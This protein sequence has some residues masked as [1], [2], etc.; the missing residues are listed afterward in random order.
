VSAAPRAEPGALE[1][2]REELRRWLAANRPPPP[3]FPLPQN[4]LSVTTEAQLEWLRAWQRR[5][6]EA[7]YVGVEWPEAYGGR[8]LARGHQRVVD[9]ETARAGAPF[10][11]NNVALAWAGP[12][13][14]HHGTEAQRRRYLKPLLACE[15]IWCQGFSEPEAGSDL[16]S[17]Q[18]RARRDGDAWV[19]DGHK[20][21]TSLGQFA[22]HMILLARTDPDAPKH[23]GISYFLAPMGVPGVEVRP[24]VKMTGEGGFNQVLFHEARIPA[25]TLL[26]RE[27]EGWK[28]AV[29]TLSF[30]RGASEGSGGASDMGGGSVDDLLAL[31]RRLGPTVT[32]DPVRRDRLA[33]FVIEATALRLDG[34]R[35]RIPALVA[36]RPMALPLMAKLAASEHAQRLADFACELQG[37]AA[38]L[39]QGDPQAIDDGRWPRAYLNS[40]AL[41]I[42]G[43]TSEILRNVLGEKVLG[44]PKSR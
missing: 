8:G 7:G 36:D 33:A 3:G 38:T 35:A 32:E 22:D 37:P 17:L 29:A 30:E 11:V 5:L 25:D 20:V 23:A 39:W 9:Q 43:G 13:I 40:F 41:T 2:F 6:Y 44:L 31:A 28:L 26:G 14:L 21:W 12:I 15:E 34:E 4:A 19:I 18:T 42:A 16:A 1:R 10:L 24:L 27:G